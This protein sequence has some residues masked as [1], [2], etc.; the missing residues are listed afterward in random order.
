MTALLF[1]V[2]LF[3]RTCGYASM[4]TDPEKFQAM[5]DIGKVMEGYTVTSGRGAI[6]LIEG[7]YVINK[8]G[9]R[10]ALPMKA[11]SPD[12]LIAIWTDVRKGAD[13]KLPER[14]GMLG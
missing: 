12:R 6:A 10:Y 8:N 1:D 13:L 2:C 7:N 11:I 14:E 4:D 5:K 3:C 9:R